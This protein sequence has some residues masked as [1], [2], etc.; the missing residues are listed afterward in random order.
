[1]MFHARNLSDAQGIRSLMIFVDPF[2][3]GFYDKLGA[4]FLY[5]SPSSIQGRKI[6]VYQR[7]VSM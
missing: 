6:P 4:V 5:D 7:V 2:A 3:R 1:M